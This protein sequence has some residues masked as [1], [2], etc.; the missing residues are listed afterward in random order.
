MSRSTQIKTA[1]W[2]KRIIE[3]GNCVEGKNSLLN[4]ITSWYSCSVVLRGCVIRIHLWSLRR[5]DHSGVLIGAGGTR[6]SDWPACALANDVSTRID[7]QVAASCYTLPLGVIALVPRKFLKHIP[8]LKT[9]PLFIARSAPL[10]VLKVALQL[11][12]AYVE[13]LVIKRLF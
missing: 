3:A 11:F 5:D 2:P 1:R 12:S 13:R 9:S 8:F 4:D 6:R 10:D 7:R